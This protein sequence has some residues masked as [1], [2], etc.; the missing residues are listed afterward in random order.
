M[1]RKEPYLRL[2]SNR[3]WWMDEYH[4]LC[5][6]FGQNSFWPWLWHLQMQ[7]DR[8]WGYEGSAG[9]LWL[10]GHKLSTCNPQKLEELLWHRGILSF[11]SPWTPLDKVIC[12]FINGL[13]TRKH[14]CSLL[15]PSPVLELGFYLIFRVMSKISGTVPNSCCVFAS[16][17]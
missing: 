11:S 16:L 13:T 6:P 12:Q 1:L 2:Q 15:C 4:W 5:F 10:P 9:F 7:W 17:S 14:F 8:A 3:Q